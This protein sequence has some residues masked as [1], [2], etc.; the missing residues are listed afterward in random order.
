[1]L[2]GGDGNRVMVR[3]L[4]SLFSLSLTMSLLLVLR[5]N[6]PRIFRN[7]GSLVFDKASLV[8]GEPVCGRGIEWKWN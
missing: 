5:N 8:D 2:E 6:K 1:M 4:E 3:S 7:E